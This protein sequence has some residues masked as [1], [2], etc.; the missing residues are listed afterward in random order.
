MA[1]REMER[2][3]RGHK[4]LDQMVVGPVGEVPGI[5]LVVYGNLDRNTIRPRMSFA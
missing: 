5:A 1:V 2:R 3:S 4:E